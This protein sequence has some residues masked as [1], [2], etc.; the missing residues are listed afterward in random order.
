MKL[1]GNGIERI[2]VLANMSTDAAKWVD[3]TS[4]ETLYIA[5]FYNNCFNLFNKFDHL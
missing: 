3:S 1:K 4:T 5:I 2:L